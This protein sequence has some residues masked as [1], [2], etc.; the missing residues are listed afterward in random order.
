M[1]V[2]LDGGDAISAVLAPDLGDGSQTT[3]RALIPATSASFT[4]H[5]ITATSNGVTLNVSDVMFGD[6]FLWYN[7]TSIDL[8]YILHCH[9]HH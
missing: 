9:P 4:H 7:L 5:I 8:I 6:V 1:S 2:S 3:W